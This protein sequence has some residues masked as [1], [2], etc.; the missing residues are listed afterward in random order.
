MI[1]DV[2]EN[3]QRYKD[4]Y[5]G[6]KEAFEFIEKAQIELPPEGRYEIDGKNIYSYVQEYE[7]V[8]PEECKWEAHKRYIDIQFIHEGTE[9]INW[10]NIKNLPEGPEYVDQADC[11]AYKGSGATSLILHAGSYAIFFPEDLHRPKECFNAPSP[12]KKI[13][14]KVRVQ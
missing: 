4:L 10:D 13:V 7:T 5:P 12:V 2:L 3:A 14:V 1:L 9:V 6:F 8:L 11:Y